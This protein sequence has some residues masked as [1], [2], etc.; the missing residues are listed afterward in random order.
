MDSCFPLSLS[1]SEQIGLTAASFS[2]LSKVPQS[3]IL[4]P[5]S[6]TCCP[7]PL[8][9]GLQPPCCASDS[10]GCRTFL[11]AQA[12]DVTAAEACPLGLAWPPIQWDCPTCALHC[13]AHSLPATLTVSLAPCNRLLFSFLLLSMFP[14][15]PPWPLN[16]GC[17]TWVGLQ[18]CS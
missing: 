13:A 14:V 8:H 4:H 17:L 16:P 18:L 9:P 12:S 1:L 2:L 15:A 6:R 5:T 3:W 7:C 11:K 10:C